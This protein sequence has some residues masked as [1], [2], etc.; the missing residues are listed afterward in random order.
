MKPRYLV[1]MLLFVAAMA[2]LF[3]GCEKQTNAKPAENRPIKITSAALFRVSDPGYVRPYS[4]EASVACWATEGILIA[5]DHNRMIQAFDAASGKQLWQREFQRHLIAIESSA[6]YVYAVLDTSYPGE[7]A[8]TIRRLDVMTGEDSTPEGIPQLLLA[9]SLVWCEELEVLC[10]LND[11]ELWIYS[12]DLMS[13]KTRIPYVGG[14]PFVSYSSKLILAVEHQDSCTLFDL[15][16]GSATRVYGPPHRGMADLPECD[17]PAL[18]SAFAAGDGRFI[19]VADSGWG[20]DKVHFQIDYTAEPRT[21]VL[22]HCS[23]VASIHWPSNR[24]AISVDDT[25]LVFFSTTGELLFTVKDV[26]KGGISSLS[27][28]PSGAKIAALFSGDDVSIFDVK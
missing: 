17:A 3:A 13:V 1:S 21:V 22:G 7:K 10:I 28:S 8:E 19:R 9:R 11:E 25:N 6:R 4:R 20:P 12:A 23:G 15:F 18:L 2:V 5:T 26:R 27:F 24:L 16:R 14:I